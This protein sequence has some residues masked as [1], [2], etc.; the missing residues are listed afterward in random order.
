MKSHRKE[1]KKMGITCYG[2]GEP[3]DKVMKGDGA[4]WEVLDGQCILTIGLTGISK[5][6]REAVESGSMC[7]VLSVIDNI[8]LIHINVNGKLLFDVPFHAGLYDRF[9]LNPPIE[10]SNCGY[11][12][13]VILV[14]NTTNLICAMRVISLN[15]SFSAWFYKQAEYQSRHPIPNY[16]ETLNQIFAKYDTREIVKRGSCVCMIQ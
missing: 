2:I 5:A 13:P 14:D 10:E 4:V 9:T 15:H 16:D 11:T 7:F 1:L 12:L 6:E 8:I 3:Y